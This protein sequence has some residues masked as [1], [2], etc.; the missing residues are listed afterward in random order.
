MHI[1]YWLRISGASLLVILFGLIIASTAPSDFPSG[2]IV[3]I[4]N[5]YSLSR[6]ATTLK[7]AGLVRSKLL[8]RAYVAFFGG[9]N[10]V[11]A[12]TYLFAASES[13]VS[14]AHRVARGYGGFP[15]VKVTIPEGSETRDIA[16]IIS[17]RISNFDTK[18]FL[19]LA[20]PK[21]GFLFPDTYFW[22]ANLTPEQAVADMSAIFD[23]KIATIQADIDDSDRTLR[24]IIIMASIVEKEAS[25]SADRKVIAGI[26][27][28]RLSVGMALQADAT[29]F[30]AL[31]TSTK[32][33]T[34]DDLKMKSP[35]N[36]Y[37][38]RGLP[39]TPI[40]SPGLATIIDTLHPKET[41]S[42]YYL[43]DKDGVTHYATT[44]EGH[45]VNRVKYLQ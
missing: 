42:W 40:G 31:S 38:N 28:K 1:P 45:N 15:I 23:R 37:R 21:E 24:D 6:T 14:V 10:G 11:K 30:Y 20:K 34:L 2:K 29:F 35:Y 17:Q 5:G 25:S 12:G 18:A 4:G 36:S 43:S 16:A 41:A 22:P 9:K 32:V 44:L 13:A 27:W 7:E 39:P 33:L 26:L 3:Q 19:M 8:F